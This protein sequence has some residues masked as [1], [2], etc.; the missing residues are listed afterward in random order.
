MPDDAPG[1]SSR[2]EV[3]FQAVQDSPDFARLRK[4]L[5]GFVF[6][7]TVAFLSW[8]LLY[9]ILTA[10]ARDFVSTK[11]F[12]SVNVGFLLGWGQFV[13]TFL[14]AILYSRWADKKFDPLAEQIRHELEGAK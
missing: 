10:Y 12:G 5:R 14:I 13:T 2:A 3:D 6:P 11:V 1:T 8:Y 9:V 4:A 7:M